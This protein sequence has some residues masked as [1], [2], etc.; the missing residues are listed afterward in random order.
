MRIHHPAPPGDESKCEIGL[1]RVHPHRAEISGEK[2]LAAGHQRAMG[3]I[4]AV[5]AKA[6]HEIRQPAGENPFVNVI[7]AGQHGGRTPLLEGPAEIGRL[8]R[9]GAV[10]G[11]GRIRRVMKINQL[12]RRGRGGQ[13][14]S[15]PLALDR[16]RRDPIRLRTVAVETEQ[17]HRP[18]G[19][20]VVTLIARQR[21]I[22]Q[23]AGSPRRDPI[24]I[25]QAGKESVA[26]RARAKIPDV[27]MDEL[28]VKLPDVCVDGLRLAGRIIIVPQR[29]DEG[30]P[31]AFH[32]PGD[33]TFIGGAIPVVANGGKGDVGG[34]SRNKRQPKQEQTDPQRTARGKSHTSLCGPLKFCHA[35]TAATPGRW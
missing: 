35:I 30:G 32:Q 13:F 31:P 34:T 12:P 4:V 3:R 6:I 19:E 20:R 24:V 33:I 23:V 7:V 21:E 2:L 15:Q 5:A 18:I 26:A 27:R 11:A 10:P 22:V 1:R 29:D 8:T 14:P 25:A 16:F 9:I 17:L 28:V